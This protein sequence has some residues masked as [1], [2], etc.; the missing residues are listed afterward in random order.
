MMNIPHAS[1]DMWA[2]ARPWMDGMMKDTYYFKNTKA[3]CW[4]FFK[5]TFIKSLTLL[6]LLFYCY[7]MVFLWMLAILQ[8]S[9]QCVCSV[10]A[11]FFSELTRH[12]FKKIA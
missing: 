4:L 5:A 8:E 7:S 2:Q 11:Q 6:F 1:L 3:R 12:G 10:L 9:L